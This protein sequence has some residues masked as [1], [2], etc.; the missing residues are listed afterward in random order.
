MSSAERISCGVI[1]L[2]I[3]TLH[4][5]FGFVLVT[6]GGSYFWC[7]YVHMSV[8]STGWQLVLVFFSVKLLKEE[9]RITTPR[10]YTHVA[11][12]KKKESDGR[13]L[14]MMPRICG[15]NNIPLLRTADLIFD[16][17]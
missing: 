5:Q 13:S 2:L 9:K 17:H 16:F 11:E 12:K 15:L 8:Y 10:K 1:L 3:H 14:L 4:T 7:V 6:I